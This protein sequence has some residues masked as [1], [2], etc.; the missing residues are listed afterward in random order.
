[1]A[2]PPG[3]DGAAPLLPAASGAA[4]SCCADARVHVSVS[5]KGEESGSCDSAHEILPFTEGSGILLLMV[6]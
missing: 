4:F 2:Q 6:L 1:M 5:G 3:K